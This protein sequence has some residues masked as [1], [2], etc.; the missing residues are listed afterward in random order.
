[1]SQQTSALKKETS[2][3]KVAYC[4]AVCQSCVW[5]YYVLLDVEFPGRQSALVELAALEEAAREEEM[6]VL[7][8]AITIFN[9]LIE[10][11]L[12]CIQLTFCAEF[13][14]VLRISLQTAI[15]G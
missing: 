1:M 3:M 6:K 2:T 15:R 14:E 11:D 5:C 8:D 12:L 7:K 13:I 4:P 10:G 9:K